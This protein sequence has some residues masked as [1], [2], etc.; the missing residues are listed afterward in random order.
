MS[1]APEDPFK[2]FSTGFVSSSVRIVG[3]R[4][5]RLAKA[6]RML[7][8]HQGFLDDMLRGIMPHDLVLLGAWSGVGKTAKATQ[9]A[10][11]N[12]ESGRRVAYIAL[13][14]EPLEI[15]RR[16]KYQILVRLAQARRA[17]GADDASY[18][19]WYLGRCT[20]LDEF[21]DEA[22][23][24]FVARYRGLKTFYRGAKFNAENLSTL[25]HA[26]QDEVDLVVVDHLHY[27]DL[28]EGLSENAGYRDLTKTIRDTSLSTGKPVLVVVHLRK[29]DRVGRGIV[30]TLDDI[31][32]SSDIAKIATRV[33]MI[34][35]AHSIEATKWYLSPTFVLVP[36][37]RVGG[38][39]GFVA[40]CQFD[41]RSQ[42]YADE[43]TLGRVS[44]GGYGG[45]WEPI[46][47]GVGSAPRWATRHRPMEG[48]TDAR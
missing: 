16:V 28:S 1:D 38:A 44:D 4:E 15:E 26:V 29:R 41:R 36:K 37:D 45:K 20:A 32:G 22:D 23:R 6:K 39:T 17:D 30:P 10:M 2:D 18:Q 19:D 14:A 8:Y 40:L 7:P 47:F 9:I 43:Y 24:L 3:E 31:H 12:V 46:D 5:E 13:E 11:K 33:V 21:G 35:P 25:V 27:V 34:A 48:A 42:T